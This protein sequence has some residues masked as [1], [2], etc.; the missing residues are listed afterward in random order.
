VCRATTELH[1]LA[2]ESP[3]TAAQRS[4][5]VA[6]FGFMAGLLPVWTSVGLA[7]ASELT[8]NAKGHICMRRYVALSCAAVVQYYC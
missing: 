1:L 7:L 2:V 4:G 5:R 3:T 8:G 6:G